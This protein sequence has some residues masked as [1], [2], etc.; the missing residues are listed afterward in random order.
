MKIKTEKIMYIAFIIYFFINTCLNNQTLEIFSTFLLFILISLFNNYSFK[1]NKFFYFEL[2]FIIFAALH[3]FL[4]SKLP[5]ESIKM[6]I[7]L[8]VK[9][10][11]Q[12]IIYNFFVTS[13]N[14]EDILKKYVYPVTFSMLVLIFIYI[15]FFKNS[16]F[17]LSFSNVDL[18]IFGLK[19]SGVGT[20]FGYIA[21][22]AFCIAWIL[23][24]LKKK[25]TY[26]LSSIIFFTVVILSGTRKIILPCAVISFLVPI[27]NTKN[28]AKV[29]HIFKYIFV[30]LCIGVLMFKIPL[31]YNVLGVRI[32]RSI[33]GLN[34]NYVVDNSE[35][36]R[37]NLKNTA[38]IKFKEEPFLGN[39]LSTFKK[40]YGNGL[41]SHSNIWELLYS[42][43]IIGYIIYYSKYVYIIVMLLK[44]INKTNKNEDLIIL[45]SFLILNICMLILE[46]WQVTYYVSR[47]SILNILTIALI[48]HQNS[49]NKEIDT[50]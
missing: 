3:S 7:T 35:A 9:F 22:V 33:N 48:S 34:S 46:Y 16:L 38:K 23:F 18:S 25:K 1:W 37:N 17:R 27:M 50:Q 36:I 8:C 28:Y 41:Y 10:V 43:G 2:T 5:N 26:L 42:C 32:E 24:I 47:L 44:C 11:T 14:L 31:F 39:G 13:K 20:T 21:G 4:F 45:K 12:I 49:E 6:V 30:I 15:R 40:L 29:L 19:F